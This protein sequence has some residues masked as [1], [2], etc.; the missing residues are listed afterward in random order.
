MAGAWGLRRT[1]AGAT[2]RVAVRFPPAAD[3]AGPLDGAD[4]AFDVEGLSP[5][6]T[7][8][9]RFFRI[10]E[11]LVAPALAPPPPLLPPPPL[12]SPPPPLPPP[13]LLA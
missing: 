12:V 3:P 11:A 7:P 13:P 5:L 8:P 6:V 2:G 10:D 9:E 1:G 4:T